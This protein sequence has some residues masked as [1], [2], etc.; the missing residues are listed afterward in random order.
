VKVLYVLDSLTPGGTETSTVTLLPHLRARG[1]DSTIAVLRTEPDDLRASAE[2]AGTGV[3]VVEPATPW[4]RVRA[5]RAIVRDLRP[6]LVH[7]ALYTADQ[8]GRVAAA[9][10]GAAVVSSFV[11][12]PYDPSRTNDPNVTRWRLRAAQAVDAVTGRLLVDRFH[13]VSTGVR[14]ANCRALRIPPSRATVAERGRSTCELG[15]RSPERRAR[16]RRALGLGADAPVVLNLGRLDHQKGQLV[17]LESTERIAR[18]LPDVQVVIAG[19]DGSAAA[20][21]RERLERDPDLARH[22]RLLGHRTDVGDLLCAADCLAISSHV[23]GTAGAALEAMA[24]RTPVVSTRVAGAA[25]I[26]DEERNAVIV[27][28]ADPEALATGLVRLLSDTELASRLAHE[29]RSDFEQRFTEPAA[30]DRL[31]ELYRSVLRPRPAPPSSGARPP[32]S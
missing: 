30:A 9:R 27:P 29:G 16:A 11:N 23:E 17:L 12:T 8:I 22:V 21:L 28:I 20:E 6:D 18:H 14:D 5:L 10:T 7:T 15:E 1:V 19:K 4:G 32:R 26:L 24:T 13:A 31:V 2:A 3:R 25:G